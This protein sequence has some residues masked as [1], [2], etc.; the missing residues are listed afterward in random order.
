VILGIRDLP[1]PARAGRPPDCDIDMVIIHCTGPQTVHD[2]L[3]EPA[4]PAASHYVVDE[5]GNVFRLVPEEFLARHAGTACWRGQH[6]L[7]G[8]SIGVALVNGGHGHV[9]RDFPV[10]Q[11]ASVCDLCLEILSRHAVPPRNFIGIGDAA[12]DRSSAPGERF[13]WEGLARN[14]VGL[15]PED[16][17]DLGTGGAVRD[18]A[19]LRDVRAALAHVGYDVAPEGPL[20][21]ALSAVLRAFQRH[22]RQEAV[23]GQAD[24]G[25]LARLLAVAR[26]CA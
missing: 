8:R 17:P 18:A 14:D 25:T 9:W 5:D 11:L 20:D 2:R 3:S 12:P 22:W 21:P 10:L 19:S 26:M 15:W 13:D 7:D 6:G 24:A 4:A 1:G 23:T 16:V